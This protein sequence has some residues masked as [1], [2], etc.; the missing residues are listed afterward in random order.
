MIEFVYTAGLPDA[1]RR[2]C[3][4]CRF[5]QGAVNLWCVS[6]A[7]RQAH[8]TNLPGRSACAF[9]EPMLNVHAL[10]VE[11]RRELLAGRSTRVIAVDLT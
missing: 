9:W 1:E 5:L 3:K 10:T 4:D 7:A 2:A 11:E 6:D 8:G